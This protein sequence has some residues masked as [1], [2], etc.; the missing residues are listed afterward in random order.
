MSNLRGLPPLVIAILLVASIGAVG[1]MMGSAS[2]YAAYAAQ[3]SKYIIYSTDVT[4][5]STTNIAK[6]HLIADLNNYA[7]QGYW[8]TIDD[9]FGT[10]VYSAAPDN[11][12]MMFASSLQWMKDAVPVAKD[13]HVSM[14]TYNAESW[15]YTPLW[16]QNNPV[17]A[18]SN[19][20]YTAHSNGF[21]FAYNPTLKIFKGPNVNYLKQDW[22]KCDMVLI[23]YAGLLLFPTN[24]KIQV[25]NVVSHIK[26]ENPNIEIIIGVSLRYA[27]PDQIITAINSVRPYID[28]TAITH[29]PDERCTYCTEANLDKLMAGLS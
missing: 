7:G 16:E 6:K 13:H 21:K 18:F 10:E 12:R 11:K 2:D 4:K 5:D 8:Q 17:Q 25:Q 14:L 20:A 28:G 19:A 15:E 9:D 23:P 22:T 3:T 27:N 24:F 29:H 26:S 1:Q